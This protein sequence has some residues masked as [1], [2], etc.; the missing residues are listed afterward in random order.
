[1]DYSLVIVKKI[2]SDYLDAVIIFFKV[3]SMLF[4]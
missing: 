1:M 4:T 3:I 2:V